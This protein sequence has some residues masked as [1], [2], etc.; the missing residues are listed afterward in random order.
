MSVCLKLKISVTNKPIEVFS[1]GNIST[2]PLVVLAIFWGGWDTPL[3]QK[4]YNPY[5]FIFFLCTYLGLLFREYT[6][7]FYSG[8][9]LFSWGVGQ[10]QPP[11]EEITLFPKQKNFFCN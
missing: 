11:Q 3:P 5:N 2:S 4:K 10:P 1:L 7:W 8:F 9:K 6:Y